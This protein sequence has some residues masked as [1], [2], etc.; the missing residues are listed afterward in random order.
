MQWRINALR[1]RAGLEQLEVFEALETTMEELRVAVEELRLTNESLRDSRAEVEAER[2]RYRDLFDLAPDAYLV[3][4]L[5]GVIREA[6]HAATAQ[7]NIETRL[8]V[9]KPLFVFLPQESRPA[10]RVE[11]ARLRRETRTAEYDVRLKPRKLPLFDAS[12]RVGVVRDAWGQPVALRW[13]IRDFSSKKRAEEKI[14]ALNAQLERRVFE[15]SEQLESVLQANERMLIKAH[16]ADTDSDAEATVGGRFFQDVIDEVDAILWRADAATGRYTFV[17][18]RAEELLGYPASRWLED[19]N[20]WLD[21]IHPEDR[22]WAAAYRRKQ[23]RERVDHEAEYRVVAK[24]GRTLWFREAVRVLEHEPDG[25]SALYGLMVNI[26]KRKKVERQLYTAKGELTA[27][28]RD[29]TYLHELGRRLIAARGWRSTLDEV[30]SAATSLQGAPMA[31]LLIPNPEADRLAIA[32]SSGLPEEFVRRFGEDGFE[33]GLCSNRPLA[34]EDVEAESEG[35]AW[36]E[37]A[38]LGGFRALTTVPLFTRDGE[39]LGSIVTCFQDP[40]R[41]PEGQVR[42]IEMYA[43]KA[44][45]AIEAARFVGRLEGLDRRDNETLAALADQM[46]TP[47][48]AILQAAEKPDQGTIERQARLLAELIDKL[49]S[50][51]TS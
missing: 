4:D 46:R 31:M 50:T 26:T 11:I 10:F 15:R 24:D 13:T 2:K 8:L 22:D 6:N 33:A 35:S 51:H 45:E 17:S 16:A 42:L 3:T 37:A 21:R 32:A 23:L 5:L 19:P 41:V 1:P 14:R 44:A 34:I 39:A 28:L 30:L 20:F 38:R 27:R 36:R 40:W 25:P 49:S 18:R 9:G 48:A 47:L 7:F 43:E 12:I 29:M